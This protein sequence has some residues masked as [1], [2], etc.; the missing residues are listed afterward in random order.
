MR[1][2]I[3]YILMMVGLVLAIGCDHANLDVSSD[4]NDN[5][6]VVDIPEYGYIYFDGM[7][8]TKGVLYETSADDNRLKADFGVIGYTHSYNSWI[9]AESQATPN[10]FFQQKI[11]WDG[12]VHTYSPIQTWHGKQLYAFFAYYPYNLTTS[13][14]TLEGNPYI[15]FTFKRSSLSDQVDVMTGHNIDAD[16]RTRSVGF[17]MKHRL[18]AV[19]VVANNLYT[20]QDEIKITSI[21]IKLNNL[22]Y[23]EVNI[24]MNMRDITGLDYAYGMATNKTATFN[25]MPIGTA[26]LTIG[27]QT[28][29]ALTSSDRKTTMILIP[30]EQYI[31]TNGDDVKEDFTMTGSVNVA[32]QTIKNGTPTNT[33]AAKDYPFTVNR[34]LIS[35]YR[36]YIQLNFA[37]GDITI[38]I[39]ESDLWEEENV[40]HDF[41]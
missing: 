14:K 23:D 32:Y 8:E 10:V 38:A 31:D 16:Y 5:N 18:T 21:T 11:T 2:S 30:Q 39:L 34:S 25:L 9:D 13:T 15:Y 24:P 41:E 26:S 37:A 3:K 19:D 6:Q 36:Y 35:G 33:I 29:T 7:A 4:N 20:D 12:N 40:K 28:N 22:L 27:K 17:D 1:A